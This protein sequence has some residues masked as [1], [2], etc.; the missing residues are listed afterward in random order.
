M[1]AE[2]AGLIQVRTN[3]V[4]SFPEYE[5][6]FRRLSTYEKGRPG[7]GLFHWCSLLRESGDQ[8][9]DHAIIRRP[10]KPAT[11]SSIRLMIT[12][13]QRFMVGTTSG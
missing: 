5:A 8:T 13:P 4:Q 10:A 2:L 12:R 7:G 6:G 1:P 9:I 3:L 11:S